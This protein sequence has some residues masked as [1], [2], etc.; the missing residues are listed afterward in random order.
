MIHLDHELELVHELAQARANGEI[1]AVKTRVCSRVL[2]KYSVQWQWQKKAKRRRIATNRNTHDHH[3]IN[4]NTH[5][6]YISHVGYLI[7]N[8]VDTGDTE[9]LES[10][11]VTLRAYY[12]DSTYEY[13]MW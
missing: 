4:T 2:R 12:C 6:S 8:W 5:N 7:Q 11:I 1:E 3:R 10:P 13:M 9:P